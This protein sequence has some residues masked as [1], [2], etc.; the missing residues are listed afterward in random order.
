MG[1]LLDPDGKPAPKIRV[2]YNLGERVRAG[3]GRTETD[4]DGY[5]RFNEL[6]NPC[7]FTFYT[8]APFAPIRDLPLPVG[9]DEEIVVVMEKE[10]VLRVRAIDEKTRE[11]IPAFNVKLGFS[12]DRRRGDPRMSI[13]SQF[14]EPGTDVLG[15]VKFFR[16][17]QL[18]QGT[19]FQVTVSA[20]GYEKAVVRRVE[21]R[22]ETESEVLDVALARQEENSLRTVSGFLRDSDRRPV[23]GA[24]MHLIVG[25][26]DPNIAGWH[27]NW[28]LIKSEQIRRQ[29]ECV[30][31]LTT[32]SNKDGS[33]KFERAK[34]ASWMQI[35]HMDGG[36]ANGRH[37]V[38][39]PLKVTSIGPI[40]GAFTYEML[41]RRTIIVEEDLN[42]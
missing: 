42:I 12:P 34:V 22:L 5:F 25:E 8:L 33:F 2:Y 35:V 19:P 29:A 3:G 11:P 32:T 17:G 24:K 38:V 20:N 18:N 15:D 6:P 7:T 41:D 1:R 36:V 30:Q 9:T 13:P 4:A 27:A 10:G 26:V 31:F 37:T 14:F 23:E 39:D 16:L 40:P 28:T 21:A